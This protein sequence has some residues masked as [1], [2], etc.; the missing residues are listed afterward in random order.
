MPQILR[1]ERGLPAP[2]WLGGS[3]PSTHVGALSIVTLSV[4]PA[5]RAASTDLGPALC[6]CDYEQCEDSVLWRGHSAGQDSLSMEPLEQSLVD[7][8]SWP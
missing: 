6:R 1:L 2:C 5:A 7:L 4:A 8:L 3:P